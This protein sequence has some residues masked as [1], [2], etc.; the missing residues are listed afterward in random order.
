[1]SKVILETNQELSVEILKSIIGK[2]V[3]ADKNYL[4]IPNELLGITERTNA[5]FA[6]LVAGFEQIWMYYDFEKEEFFDEPKCYFSVIM[7]DGTAYILSNDELRI[8]ELTEEEFNQMVKDYK[9][10]QIILRGTR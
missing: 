9:T 5:W 8:L 2:Y 1:M 6:G 7:S 3:H 4:D 10:K